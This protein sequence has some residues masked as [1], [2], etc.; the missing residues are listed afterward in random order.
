MTRWVAALCC[1]AAVLPGCRVSQRLAELRA[2]EFTLDR[3][4]G[5]RVAGMDLARL[6]SFDD[7]SDAQRATI[8]AAARAG[9]VPLEFSLIVRARNPAQNAATAEL[10]SMEWTL[11]LAERDTVSGRLDRRVQIRSGEIIEV[12]VPVRL[13]LVQF[14]GRDDRD[15]LAALRESIGPAGVP[16]NLRLRATPSVGTA[17]GPIGARVPIE[18]TRRV[19]VSGF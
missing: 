15:L 19:G 11:L 17:N 5:L 16:I 14:F 18:I 4:D 9:D 7:L 3:V 2:A 12:P 10:F 13:N 8:A 1:L 6:R